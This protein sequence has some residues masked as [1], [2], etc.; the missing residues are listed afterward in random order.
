VPYG[1]PPGQ[2]LP[3]PVA[4]GSVKIVS[5]EGTTLTLLATDGTTFVFDGI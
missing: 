5:A 4:A 3:T 1:S 2:F